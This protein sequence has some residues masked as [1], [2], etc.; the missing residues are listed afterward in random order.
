[1]SLR[2]ISLVYGKEMRD[3]LRDRRTLF[4]SVVLPILLYP[5]LMIGLSQVVMT[6]KSKIEGRTQK[7][8]V[9]GGPEVEEITARLM[10]E[11]EE[12]TDGG[13]L[14]VVESDDP[15]ASV[16][17]GEIDLWIE[18]LPGFAD[19]LSAKEQGKILV[20]FDSTKDDSRAAERKAVKALRLYGDAVLRE[21]GLSEA[22]I[23]P[24]AMEPKRLTFQPQQPLSSQAV[25]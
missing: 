7:V 17:E 23:E 19:A 15:L 8:V 6:A 10:A 9:T 22:D 5:I 18:I 13:G 3:T 24:V 20:H 11:A 14:E 12:D 4:I 21:R 16:R 25:G 2:N 1:M